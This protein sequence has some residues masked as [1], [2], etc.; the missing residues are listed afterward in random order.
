MSN[1]SSRAQPRDLFP[2][3][4]EKRFLRCGSLRSPSVGTT[5]EGEIS[6]IPELPVRLMRL[7]RNCG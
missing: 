6:G 2:V 5:V 7:M 4:N 3:P 1:P